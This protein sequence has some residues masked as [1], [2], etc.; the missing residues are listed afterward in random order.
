MESKIFG[1][2]KRRTRQ[3][4]IADQSINHLERFILDEGHTAQ[5]LGS[6]YGYDLV[7][8]TYDELGYIEPDSMYFQVKAAETLKVVGADYA[9]DIDIRDYNLWMSEKMLVVL[10]LFDASRRRAYWLVIQ[11]YFREVVARQPKRG[12]KTVRIRV[13][14]RQIVNRRAIAMMRD[15]KWEALRQDT[16]EE[17]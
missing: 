17:P 5:R 16:R 1:P 15:L 10:I 8:S 12:A 3:H 4:V 9:Y 6:D 14:R 2:R 7:L 13:P 11:H